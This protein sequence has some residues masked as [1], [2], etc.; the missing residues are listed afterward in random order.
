MLKYSIYLY[1]E[2]ILL[3]NASYQH[4][5]ILI[6]KLLTITWLENG[7]DIIIIIHICAYATVQQL[8]WKKETNFSL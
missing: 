6:V 7:D 3:Q 2:S 1:S 4:Y 5:Q 8:D